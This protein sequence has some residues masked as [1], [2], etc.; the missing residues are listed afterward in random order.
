MRIESVDDLESL[1]AE[2]QEPAARS[3]NVFATWEWASTWWRHFGAGR[4]LRL[5]SCRARDAVTAI[6]PLHVQKRGPLRILRFLGHG[7]GD[8]LGP[9]CDPVDTPAAA[10]AL[11]S[12]L[13]Q[14]GWDVFIGE[15]LPGGEPWDELLRGRVARRSES[16]V[17]SL[18][19]PS[20]DDLLGARSANLR[21]QVRRFERRLEREG[22]GYRLADE[23][24]LS[25]D[26]DSLFALHAARWPGSRWFAGSEPFHR[27]FAAVALERGWLR[28]W[29][30]E[31]A[32]RPAAAWLGYR[33]Q[34]VESYYQAG[35]DPA[36]ER[37]SIG[38]VLLAH[39]IRQAL[40]DGMQ[41]YRFLRGG[42]SYKYRFATEDP[43]LITVIR[44]KG[45][46]GAAALVLRSVLRIGRA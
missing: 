27:D 28:L 15:E 23:A 42:E 46:L 40:E 36:W 29:I 17:L 37:E 10:G 38:L 3:R 45:P 8:Q 2:W 19:Q 11:G 14:D 1:R 39:T 6:L 41:E 43:G 32:G 13:E 33:F 21:Q 30:L 7:E 44:A 18:D 16:P 24:S 12:A 20:W 31:L 34:G 4:E 5:A 9:V 25:G 35:R 26:L 22:L